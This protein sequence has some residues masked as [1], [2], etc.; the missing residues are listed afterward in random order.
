DTD[1]D[2]TVYSKAEQVSKRALSLE[3]TICSRRE[4]T[5]TK[6][7]EMLQGKAEKA[8]SGQAD[9]DLKETGYSKAK[10]V[11]EGPLSKSRS[12][13]PIYKGSVTRKTSSLTPA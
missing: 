4:V 10:Q 12:R 2:E 3:T 7:S 5:E 13:I 1:S 8:V 9:V 6:E 11:C